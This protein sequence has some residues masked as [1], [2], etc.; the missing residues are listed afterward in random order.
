MLTLLKKAFKFVA[1]AF[2]DG[3]RAAAGYTDQPPTDS[4]VRVSAQRTG[5]VL[6]FIGSAVLHAFPFPLAPVWA[7]SL[8]KL[9]LGLWTIDPAR[10]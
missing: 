4:T 8:Y 3:L 10:N 1:R 2:V 6:A 5:A 7:D 9:G